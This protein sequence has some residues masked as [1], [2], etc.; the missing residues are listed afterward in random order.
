MSYNINILFKRF[1]ELEDIKEP[2]LTAYTMIKE[3]FSNGNRLFVCGNGGSAS[4]AE[5]IVGEL[6]KGFLLK[7]ELP[8]SEK[9]KFSAVFGEE[10][11]D[12]AGK[13][14]QGLPAIALT[15]HPSLTTAF[16]NDVDPSLSFS[17]QLYAM[18]GKGD[19]LLAISTSGNSDNVVKCIQTAQI[20]EVET[21]ILTGKNGGK[22]AE[23]AKCS[24]IAPSD[25]TY[26]IQEYHLPIYHALCAA[27][28]ENFYGA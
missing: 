19:V 28:E 9:D 24:V 22:S 6:M 25:E 23:L 26:L 2:I 20:M 10:G 5:H 8:Q 11:A 18:G 27:L 17:Q 3:A 12:I 1:P 13:L 14:Q 7:R 16:N 15:G 21:I 4:D